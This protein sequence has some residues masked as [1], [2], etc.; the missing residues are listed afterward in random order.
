[1]MLLH[2]MAVCA[3]CGFATKKAMTV[4]LSPSYGGGVVE[5]AMAGGDFFPFLWCFW[6]SSLEFTINNE[7]VVFF[8]VEGCNG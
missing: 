6:F 2:K 7:M 1:M 4:M 3:F 5:K 8:F